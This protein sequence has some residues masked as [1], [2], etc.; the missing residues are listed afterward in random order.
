M[1]DDDL[2]YVHVTGRLVMSVGDSPEDEGDKPDLVAPDPGGEAWFVP[3]V[4]RVTAPGA[5]PPVTIMNATIVA[6]LEADGTI[7]YNGAPGVWLVDL[8]SDKVTPRIPRTEP[9]YRVEFHGLSLSGRPV[10]A[11]PVLMHPLPGQDN[12]ISAGAA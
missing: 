11:L 9:A 3:L 5:S 4:T 10:E 2:D 6:P 1:S 7:T 12:D 8:G